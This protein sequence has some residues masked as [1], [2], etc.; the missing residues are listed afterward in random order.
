MAAD[1]LEEIVNL[2][3]APVKIDA[4]LSKLSTWAKGWVRSTL[5]FGFVLIYGGHDADTS[6]PPPTQ[7][8]QAE[9]T[10]QQGTNPQSA[11]KPRTGGNGI[12]ASGSKGVIVRFNKSYNNANNGIVCQDCDAPDIEYNFP[13]DNGYPRKP[14]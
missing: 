2:F 6:P 10:P 3:E 12:D 8:V 14:Q 1:G 4:A 7:M 9:A 13:H 11:S 5:V